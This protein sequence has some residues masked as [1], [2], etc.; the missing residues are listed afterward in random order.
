MAQDPDFIARFRDYNDYLDS[1]IAE[2]DIRY[3]Q[4]G[5]LARYSL[6]VSR[7]G[8]EMK[9]FWNLPNN[10]KNEENVRLIAELSYRG[11]GRTLTEREYDAE[12]ER[13]VLFLHLWLQ[14]AQMYSNNLSVSPIPTL[15]PHQDRNG[16]EAE[17]DERELWQGGRHARQGCWWWTSCYRHQTKVWHLKWPLATAIKKGMLLK[18]DSCYSD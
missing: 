14:A 9:R 15:C 12:I 5:E 8:Y 6:E 1:L 11:A 7:Q 13:F 4:D 2:E 17:G 16:E 10:F 18:L 3:L